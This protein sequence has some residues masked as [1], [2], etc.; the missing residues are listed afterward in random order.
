MPK[1]N[2]NKKNNNNKLRNCWQNEL[3]AI[4]PLSVLIL[5]LIFVILL[6][7]VLGFQSK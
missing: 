1:V 5:L 3:M 6:I 2:N 7:F 4:F